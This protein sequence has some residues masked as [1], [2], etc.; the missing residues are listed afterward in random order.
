[1]RRIPSR[2]RGSALVIVVVF[3][4]LVLTLVVTNL[5][6]NHQA[7]QY[8]QLA[9]R[10]DQVVYAAQAGLAAFRDQITFPQLA[11]STP[12]AGATSTTL[13]ASPPPYPGTG[14]PSTGYSGNHNLWLHNL[15]TIPY[16]N[17]YWAPF[18]V[19]N[20]NYGTHPA[21]LK[22]AIP[23]EPTLTIPL[24][25][26][27]LQVPGQQVANAQVGI[28][29]WIWCNNTGAAAGN[30]YLLAAYAAIPSGFNSATS[31]WTYDQE[32]L[33]QALRENQPFSSYMF[34][35]FSPS[36]P[37]YLG[38][39]S[40][41]G[42]ILSNDAI[43]FP[44]SGQVSIS[45]TASVPNGSST[46]GLFNGTVS[47][48][49]KDPLSNTPQ[50]NVSLGGTVALA[51]T[52]S[53]PS[54]GVS[55]EEA[56][57]QLSSNP[58]SGTC[59]PAAATTGNFYDI[60]KGSSYPGWPTSG[61]FVNAVITINNTTTPTLNITTWPGTGTPGNVTNTY[62]SGA[63]TTYTNVPFPSQG[64]VYVDGNVTVV[65]PNGFSGNLTIVSG[66]GNVVIGSSIPYQDPNPVNGAN[67]TN[68]YVLAGTGSSSG[69]YWSP[70]SA[71]YTGGFQPLTSA[72]ANWGSNAQYVINPNWNSGTVATLGLMAYN[73]IQTA[74]SGVNT[75]TSVPGVGAI[76]TAP[77]NLI[78]NASM[79]A[80]QGSAFDASA[81]PGD[82]F[83]GQNLALAGSIVGTNGVYRSNGS[84]G[85]NT[86][87]LYAWDPAGSKN[88]PPGWLATLAPAF[89]AFHARPVYSNPTAAA[90]PSST[91]LASSTNSSGVP[92][93][94]LFVAGNTTGGGPGQ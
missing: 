9:S 70:G 18:F 77:Q 21:G 43:V 17:N 64:V 23:F 83:V 44:S 62:T 73:E 94:F 6:V 46:T 66:N 34:F 84:Q 76:A 36:N 80:Q 92:A 58:A 37:L 75:P 45:G 50:S 86:S 32:L 59:S 40:V 90:F 25:E 24:P 7:V 11:S 89:G 22:N 67:G 69:T 12:Y 91:D 39:I 14:S 1:M 3:A 61:S 57:A 65:A 26:S 38:D 49:T 10:H 88:P 20:P 4:A 71:S 31:T 60:A 55:G 2:E 35:T 87:G 29:V 16:G 5:E 47:S 28:P 79:Y 72:P 51:A 78:V 68:E 15:V 41:S 13:K 27:V 48:G 81:F 54:A 74:Q 85:Y 93:A 8:T 63:T 42:S 53:L 19:I 33:V 82:T 30:T 52:A 56:T